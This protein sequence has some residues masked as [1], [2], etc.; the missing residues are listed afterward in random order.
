MKKIVALLLIVVTAA[1]GVSALAKNEVTVNFKGEKMG[2]DVS[3]FIE[4]DATLMPVRA[5]FEA[6]GASV[7]WDSETKTVLII[8]SK[9]DEQKFIILQIGNTDAFVDGEK[10]SLSV[11]PKIVGDRTFVPLRFIMETLGYEVLWDGNTRTVNIK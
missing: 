2:F 5:I 9:N 10:K 3:P 8:D 4:N 11:A 6:S 1:F 7:N